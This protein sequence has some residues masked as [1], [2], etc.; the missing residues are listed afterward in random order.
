MRGAGE[1]T[2]WALESDKVGENH[3]SKVYRGNDEGAWTPAVTWGLAHPEL[4][5]PSCCN[6]LPQTYTLCSNS[7]LQTHLAVMQVPI[8]N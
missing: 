5:R 1:N 4:Q 2:G 8:P 7:F 3:R 6:H